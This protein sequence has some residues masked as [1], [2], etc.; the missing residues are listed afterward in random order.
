MHGLYISTPQTCSIKCAYTNRC[1]LCLFVLSNKRRFSVFFL[2]LDIAAPSLAT[3]VYIVVPIL[4][5]NA[6]HSIAIPHGDMTNDLDLYLVAE[7]ASL[8]THLRSIYSTFYWRKLNAKMGKCTLGPMLTMWLGLQALYV[9]AS[10]WYVPQETSLRV[11]PFVLK[12][13]VGQPS[14]IL[15]LFGYIAE[16]TP[17]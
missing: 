6:T 17:A 5:A 11:V 9:S 7:G 13:S 16:N 8:H 15:A 10:Q 1:P 4:C 12:K 14:A 3:S 2:A